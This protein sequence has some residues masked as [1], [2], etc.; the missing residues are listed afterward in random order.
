MQNSRLNISERE[1]ARFGLRVFRATLQ[2]L[3]PKTLQIEIIDA[4]AD[5]VVIRIPAERQHELHKLGD[6]GFQYIVADTIVYYIADLRTHKTPLLRNTDLF[7]VRC[8]NDHA[9]QLD[10]LVAAIFSGYRNHYSSNPLLQVGMLAGYQEWART[11]ASGN[12]SSK[13]VWLIERKGEPIAFVTCGTHGPDE[14]EMVLNGVLPSESGRG[15]YGDII[16]HTQN[17]FRGMGYSTL[18]VSTQVQNYAVQKVWSREGFTMNK[19]LLTVHVNSL[20]SASAVPE[21]A[22]YFV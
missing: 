7:F 10:R 13:Y 15:V 9:S 18:K 20:L 8:T 12:D 2:D 5:V 14:A 19:A 16:R 11:Y 6:T 17:V 22:S 4:K 1:S 3:D 21:D